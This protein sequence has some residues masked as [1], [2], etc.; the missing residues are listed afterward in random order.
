[1]DLNKHFKIERV[2]S[3]YDLTS[4]V[5]IGEFNIDHV[6]FDSLKALFLPPV[7]D[8]LMYDCYEVDEVKGEQINVLT[9]FEFDFNRFVYFVECYQVD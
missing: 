3:W 6:P 1:M 7:E 2:I 4:D 9:E 5:L 8:P